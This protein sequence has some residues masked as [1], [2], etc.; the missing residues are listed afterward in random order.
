MRAA[1]LTE[2]QYTARQ[3]ARWESWIVGGG[4]GPKGDIRNTDIALTQLGKPLAECKVS[5]LSTGGVHVK[6]EEP[7]DLL[8]PAGDPSFRRIPADLDS[9]SLMFSHSHYN[10]RD[11]DADPNCMFPI[12]RLR[13]LCADGLV[14]GMTDTFYGLMGFVPNPRPFIDTTG[15]EIASE[16]KSTGTDIVVITAGC[17]ICHRSAALVQNI[18]EHAGMSTV[19][20]TLLPHVSKGVGVPR[21]IYLRFPQG[22]AFGE[23]FDVKMQRDVLTTALD[24]VTAV[25]TPGTILEFP[26]RWRT[27]LPEG[28][29]VCSIGGEGASVSCGGVQMLPESEYPDL[30]DAVEHYDSAITALERHQRLLENRLRRYKSEGRDPATYERVVNGA[31]VVVEDLLSMLNGDAHDQLRWVV[32]KVGV[33]DSVDQGVWV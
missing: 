28:D 15:P 14:G 1:E 21:A 18:L 23:P 2:W 31:I 3:I 30:H 26:A 12:D 32:D 25:R 5:L 29:G 22:N 4:H 27:S 11:A 7:F 16:L 17:P 13:E 10:H 33:L 24:A 19:S 9:T 20:L 6:N 8:I